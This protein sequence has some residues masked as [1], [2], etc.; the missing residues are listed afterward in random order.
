LTD[1]LRQSDAEPE[2]PGGPV[3]PGILCNP[4]GG[5]IKNHLEATRRAL[6][7]LPASMY[8]EAATATEIRDSI[9]LFSDSG[10]NLLILAGGDGTVHCALTHLFRLWEGELPAIA[11]IPGG[12]T[13]MTALD[14]GISKRPLACIARLAAALAQPDTRYYTMRRV[15]RIEQGLDTKLFGM[16]FGCG[17]IPHGVKYF[18]RRV[19]Q[20]GLTNEFAGGMVMLGYLFGFLLRPAGLPAIHLTLF[21]D[22]RSFEKHGC[23]AA[24]ATTLDRLLL[25][26][27][28]YRRLKKGSLFFTTIDNTMKSVW[29]TLISMLTGNG[30][31][32]TN[33]C[34]LA[35]T[36]RLEL[37]FDGDFIVDGELYNAQRQS[38]PII[39]TGTAPLRF[40]VV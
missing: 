17:L 21:M 7:S 25:G 20:Y 16:F 34:H 12:T 40:L 5:R 38:G 10:L 6:K 1:R 24:F 39:I 28:P 18:H 14:L 29:S 9:R 23:L 33:T 32:N 2:T 37:L 3:I 36:E 35:H 4:A 8:L 19:R 31:C 30:G 27:R 15:L 13:N 22:G 11:V 26:I